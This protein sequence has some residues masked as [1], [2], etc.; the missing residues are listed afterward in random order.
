MGTLYRRTYAPRGTKWKDAKGAG[1]LRESSVYWCKYH[2]NGRPVRE[3]TK[4]DRLEDARRFLKAREGR[5]ATGAPILPRAE[6]VRYEEVAKDLRRH[7]QAT[8]SRDLDE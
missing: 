3:S 8:G 5:V 2:V 7:Y 6:S 4:C 1:A